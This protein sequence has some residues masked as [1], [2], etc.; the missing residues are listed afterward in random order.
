MGRTAETA[1]KYA[2]SQVGKRYVWGATGPNAFDCSGLTYAAYKSA[3]VDIGRTTY[4]QVKHG[5]AVKRKDLRAGDLIFT[6]PDLGHVQMYAGDGKIVEAATPKKGIRNS[7]VT[8][9]YMA[10]RY[11][12]GGGESDGGKQGSGPKKRGED[13]GSSRKAGPGRSISGGSGEGTS[14]DRGH[15]L[16]GCGAL[17]L[18]AFL[19]WRVMKK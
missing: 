17:A 10:R 11:D 1:L 16:V 19:V 4:Q 15:F 18:V 2:K 9:V 13:S 7:T 3:G 5:T 14:T 12:N 6:S 8:T